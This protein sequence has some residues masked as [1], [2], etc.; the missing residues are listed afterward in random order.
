MLLNFK[1]HYIESFKIPSF[2]L[3]EGEI[4]IF[5]IPNIE[6]SYD[7]SRKLVELFTAIN[8]KF[9]YVENIKQNSL[10]SKLFPL[11]VEKYLRHCNQQSIFKDKIYEIDW[12]EPNTK[13]NIIAGNNRK[14][15]SL[16]K[17]LTS[18]KN[19]IIDF[20][21]CDPQGSIEIYK[22]LQEN[23]KENGS[24]IL[25]DYFKAFK[26]EDAKHIKIEYFETE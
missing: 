20:A 11:T 21:G 16:Y 18:K 4:I 12:I 15:L 26:N 6:K 3:R 7:L 13:I 22:V 19:I 14:L 24:T 17:A 8:S 23:Q 5:E 9:I 25:F 1:E 2:V 10:I